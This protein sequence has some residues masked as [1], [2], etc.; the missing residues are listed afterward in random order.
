[1]S[2][3]NTILRVSFRM[4]FSEK[5]SQRTRPSSDFTAKNK[6]VT[7]EEEMCFFAGEKSNENNGI[8]MKNTFFFGRLTRYSLYFFAHC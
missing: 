8:Q 2:I 6:D 4:E 3:K 7:S 1:M 5:G